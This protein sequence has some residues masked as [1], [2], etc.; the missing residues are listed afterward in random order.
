MDAT[1][2]AL[3]AVFVPPTEERWAGEFRAA[4]LC[5]IPDKS[6][7]KGESCKTKEE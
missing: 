2:V 4:I 6:M 3:A 7:A 5:F 1:E